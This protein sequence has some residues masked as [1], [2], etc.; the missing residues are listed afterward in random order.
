MTPTLPAEGLLLPSLS[1]V[2]LGGGAEGADL[3]AHFG[4]A[5]EHFDRDL[6]AMVDALDE[7]AGPDAAQKKAVSEGIAE[8]AR[9]ATGWLAI[10]SLHPVHPSYV[11]RRGDL[12]IVVRP[13][14]LVAEWLILGAGDIAAVVSMAVDEF[15]DVV[16]TAHQEGAIKA[17]VLIRDGV[18]H[19]AARARRELDSLSASTHRG[20]AGVVGHMVDLIGEERS[21]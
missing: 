13:M 19:P 15:P 12:A 5:T 10:T 21:T 14:G 20:L 8:L 16:I 11:L 7:D 18:V 4:V 1:L 17:S 2:L 3:L 9:E 6:Q